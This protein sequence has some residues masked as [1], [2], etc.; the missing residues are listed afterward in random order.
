MRQM[1]V[2]QIVSDNQR[3]A[4]STVTPTGRHGGFASFRGKPE[5]KST[6]RTRRAALLEGYKADLSSRPGLAVPT[7][8]PPTNTHQQFGAHRCQ[9]EEIPPQGATCAPKA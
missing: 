2:G 8:V 3:A 7:A 4:G 5:T 9:V 1:G 6:R